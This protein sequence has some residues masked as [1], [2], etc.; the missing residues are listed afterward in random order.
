MRVV[1]MG[2]VEMVEWTC[3]D[4]TVSMRLILLVTIGPA[5]VCAQSPVFAMPCV[6]APPPDAAIEPASSI[7]LLVIA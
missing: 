6:A 1:M 7:H 4:G 2:F 3:H 5:F